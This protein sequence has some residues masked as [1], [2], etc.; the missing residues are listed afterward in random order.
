MTLRFDLDD[1]Q[2]SKRLGSMPGRARATIVAKTEILRLVL[3]NKI[4]NDLLS[5]QLLKVRTGDLRRSIYSGVDDDG[6][7][8]LGWARQSASVRYGRILNDGGTTRPH[9]IFPVKANVLSFI[10]GGK[11]IFARMVHHPGSKIPAFHYMEKGLDAIAP[12]IR[13]EY[14]T[15]VRD[16]VSK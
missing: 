5:G 12:Q 4:K 10:M 3:E 14:A 1:T 6:T 8:I 13:A 11:R 15:A 9:D 16:E 2:V 7:S